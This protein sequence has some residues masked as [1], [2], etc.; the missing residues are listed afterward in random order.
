M[1]L[2]LLKYV[3]KFPILTDAA[4]KHHEYLVRSEKEESEEIRE[5]R[6]KTGRLTQRRVRVS[7]LNNDQTFCMILAFL[8]TYTAL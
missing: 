1:S 6:L 2:L 7:G 3:C 5:N 8:T 4:K